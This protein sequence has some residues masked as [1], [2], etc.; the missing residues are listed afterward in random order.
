MPFEVYIGYV[1]DKDAEIAA[2]ETLTLEVRDLDTY[3]RKIVRALVGKPDAS[4]ADS[5]ELWIL[6]WVEARQADPWRIKVLEELEEEDATGL[7]SDINDTDLKGQA[8]ASQRYAGGRG[9]GGSMPEMMG[10]EEARK[11][12]ENIARLKGGK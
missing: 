2:G 9:R 7:R 5:D 8:D 1:A 3:E 4:L 10:A 6:D 11:F 12:Y